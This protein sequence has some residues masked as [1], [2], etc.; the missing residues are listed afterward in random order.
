MSLN[1]TVI[2]RWDS[3]SAQE[4]ALGAALWHWCN[5]ASGN[6]GMYPYLDNQALADLLAGQRP[7]SEAAAWDADSPSVSF[8]RFRATPTATARRRSK[9]CVG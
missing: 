1:C 9:A 4:R 7:A 3:T 6:A 5:E 2:L 8:T